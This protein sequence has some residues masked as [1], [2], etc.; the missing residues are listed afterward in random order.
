MNPEMSLYTGLYGF[1][2]HL[3]LMVINFMIAP[4]YI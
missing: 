3:L 4:K 2:M 1:K